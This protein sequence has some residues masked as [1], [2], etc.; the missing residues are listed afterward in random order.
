MNMTEIAPS[1]FVST[2]FR[3]ATTLS[4]LEATLRIPESLRY[5]TVRAVPA[6]TYLEAFMF[7]VAAL[8]GFITIPFLER[9]LGKGAQPWRYDVWRCVQWYISFLS[10]FWGAIVM[11][12]EL[13]G[14]VGWS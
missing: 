13:R 9:V 12:R 1:W 10:A 3:L 14:S 4:H 6:D 5:F 2:M 11:V 7:C 8:H